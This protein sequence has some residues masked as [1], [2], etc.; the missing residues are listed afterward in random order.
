M[1]EHELRAGPETVHWGFFDAGLKPVLEVASGDTVIVTTCSGGE[2][3]LPREGSGMHVLP[4]HREI[5]ARHR[6]PFGP[7]I[8]TGPIFVE[9]AEPG[10]VLEVRIKA[11]EL[12][13]DWGYNVIKPLAGAIPEDFGETLREIQIPIDIAAKIARTPWGIDLPLA[14][15]FG[16]MGVAPPAAYGK[17][18][19]MVPREFGGNLDNKDLVAGATVFYPV[20]NTG[21]LFSV[22]DGHGVQGHGEVCVT[23][24]ETALRGTFELIVRKDMKLDLP[25]AETP[26][27]LV[28]MAFDVDLD[29][30]AKDA[31]RQMIRLLGE[32]AGL[33]RED[34]YQLMSL[35]C[36]LHVTQL[37]NGNKGVHAMIPKALFKS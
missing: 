15:F 29:D 4:E 14:P 13:Q 23:A 20:F 36:D 27:H 34:A 30:A 24:V 31:I 10:D 33:P 16:N 3:L 7:H 18:T 11:I 17:I 37:V 25:I 32:R 1:A 26:T 35:A 2:P 28:T 6:D 22:G 12:R 19:S 5:L 21:A 9:G 8:M